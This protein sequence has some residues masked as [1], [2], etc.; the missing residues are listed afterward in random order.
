MRKHFLY[1]VFFFQTFIK[2]HTSQLIFA[3]LIG[4]FLT[5]FIFQVYPILSAILVR[6]HETV[7]IVGLYS[8]NNLP[9][10]VKDKIS[11]GLTALMPDGQATPAAT[12]TWE[13]TN[14]LIY[15]FHIKPNLKWHDGKQFVAG[16][17]NYKVKGSQITAVDNYTLKIELKEPYSPLPVFLSQSLLR[18][19]FLGLG[20]YKVVKVEYTNDNK[21]K[22]LTLLPF[23]NDL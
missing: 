14:N 17:I 1:F 22:E 7:G 6:K 12:A 23:A 19:R 2:R 8:W 3:V 15:T 4:F 20:P 13:L 11:Y 16:D 21:I 5:L 9:K 10:V 18:E